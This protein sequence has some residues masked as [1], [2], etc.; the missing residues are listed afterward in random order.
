MQCVPEQRREPRG[1]SPGRRSRRGGSG[2]APPPAGRALVTHLR[3]GLPP[4]LPPI[5]R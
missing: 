4:I 1:P 2:R 5:D 3:V